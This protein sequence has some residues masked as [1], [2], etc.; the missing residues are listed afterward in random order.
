MFE[1][2]K[3][4]CEGGAK[5][6]PSTASSEHGSRR[7]RV[8]SGIACVVLFAAA[9]VFGSAFGGAASPVTPGGKIGTMTLVRG[10]H[11]Q[12]DLALFNVCDPVIRK[13]G[14]Y[15]RSCQVP[16]VDRI[17]LGYG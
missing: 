11:Y 9:V 14:R 6:V 1:T 2:A 16:Q 7:P 12:S 10:E 17:W 5:A 4:L 8:R 15:Q 13:A 3:I